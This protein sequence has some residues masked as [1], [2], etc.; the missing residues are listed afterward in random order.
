MADALAR[1]ASLSRQPD[2]WLYPR[3]T[4]IAATTGLGLTATRAAL[5]QLRAAGVIEAR[6]RGRRE[7]A[8]NDLK[9]R[10]RP[11]YRHR[12]RP[13]LTFALTPH[14]LLD[15]ARLGRQHRAL[16]RRLALEA[17]VIP[18]TRRYRT[19]LLSLRW[20]ALRVRRTRGTVSRQ[21]AA[22]ARLGWLRREGAGA[23]GTRYSLPRHPEPVNVGAARRQPAGVALADVR[24][25]PADDSHYVEDKTYRKTPAATP[26]VAA[27]ASAAPKA[28]AL[29]RRKRQ[30]GRFSRTRQP[31]QLT[32]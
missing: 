14:A 3:Q 1:Y 2:G 6:K 20:L 15:D 27:P 7:V 9:Y 30:G 8:G 24:V 17:K 18:G 29:F 26:P 32:W 25:A 19:R 21:V 4:T 16:Y 12:A 28:A 13:G 10:L 22:L 11:A 23:S 31:R 5:R